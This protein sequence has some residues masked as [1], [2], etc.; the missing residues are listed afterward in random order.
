MAK[1]ATNI[2]QSRKLLELGLDPKSADMRYVYFGKEDYGLEVANEF[3]DKLNKLFNAE[4]IPA[5]TLSA[6]LETMPSI[7]LDKFS[8]VYSIEYP[9]KF[10]DDYVDPLD[11]AVEMA[12][13]ML[14]KGYIHK[15]EIKEGVVDG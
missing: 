4:T 7:Q 15:I 11:A 10:T 14:K 2:E 5:W 1:I 3:D 8:D 9:E 12:E 13:W 6:L